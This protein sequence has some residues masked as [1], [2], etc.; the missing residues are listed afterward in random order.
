M[1]RKSS[2]SSASKRWNGQQRT[3]PVEALSAR[4]F[5]LRIACG[6]SVYELATKAGILAHT[7][8]RLESGRSVDKRCLPALACALSV[9][10]CRLLCGEHSCSERACVPAARLEAPG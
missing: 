10:Y 1:S 6:Y 8:Y 7:I 2:R 9:P 5:R 3:A 4:I